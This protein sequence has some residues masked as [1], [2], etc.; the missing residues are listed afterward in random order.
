MRSVRPGLTE[1][2]DTIIACGTNESTEPCLRIAALGAHIVSCVPGESVAVAPGRTILVGFGD[3]ARDADTR[4]KRGERPD[5]IVS[6]EGWRR[7]RNV[8]HRYG[9]V[10][11]ALRGNRVLVLAHAL[12]SEA[13][14]GSRAFAAQ[15]TGW[16]IKVGPVDAPHEQR[17]GGLVVVGY[18]LGWRDMR[19]YEPV[20]VGH[21]VALAMRMLDTL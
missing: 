13:P 17:E 16:T 12:T 15:A 9:F 19:A 5:A 21:C 4:L 8:E 14:C 2:A 20:I 11:D 10:M 7:E 6:V 1:S 18:D 3:G